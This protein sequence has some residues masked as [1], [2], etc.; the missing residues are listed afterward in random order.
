MAA[1]AEFVQAV[2]VVV[3]EIVGVVV[4][5][6]VAVVG[7]VAAVLTA[8]ALGDWPMETSFRPL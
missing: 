4:V 3:A 5:F 2:V 8:V 1:E 7:V 6:V